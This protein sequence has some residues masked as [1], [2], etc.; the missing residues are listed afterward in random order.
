[1][2]RR[3]VEFNILQRRDRISVKVNFKRLNR[4]IKV[5]VKDGVLVVPDTGIWPCYLVAYKEHSIVTRIGFDRSHS[6]AGICPGLDSRLHSHGVTSL[7][8]GEIGRT[9]GDRKLLIREIVKHVALVRMRL[10][11][12]VF[13]RA[14]I[15]GFAIITRARVLRRDEVSH[16]NQ[17]SVRNPVVVMGTVFVG[18]IWERSS[19]RV[20]PGARPDLI[21]VAV[22]A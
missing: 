13:M 2:L 10:A 7:V 16:V 18:S 8:K 11:P 5:H 3:R 12:G 20:D 22:Q 15:G 6:G 19:E 4:A 14:D 17:D 21:L 1:M 9:A